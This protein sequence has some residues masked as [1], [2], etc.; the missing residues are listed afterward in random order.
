VEGVEWLNNPVQV[1]I[2]EAC[3]ERACASGGFVHVSRL[4]R[5]VLWSAA[6]RSSDGDDDYGYDAFEIPHMISKRGALAIP[7]PS[8]N[9]WSATI[10][11]VP[12][13][14]RLTPA[15][16]AAVADAWTLGPARTTDTLLTHLKD[17]LVAGDT[18][19]KESALNL[20]QR[21]L[22]YFRANAQTSFDRPL[23][24]PDEV[25]ARIETLWFDGP[26]ELDWPAFAFAGND[27][28]F[29]LD[30]RHLIQ[31]PGTAS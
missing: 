6:Q 13:A 22:N 1:I 23:I 16:H 12:R 18:L 15:N 29:V 14:E 20:V 27:T 2:C 17:R 28:Y 31:L 4:D 7:I 11:E 10:R 24:N 30:R 19:E 21:T 9:E 5:Y 3:G 8:W 26:A 25:S